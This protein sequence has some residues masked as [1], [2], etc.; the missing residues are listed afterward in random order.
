MSLSIEK[1]DFDQQSQFTGGEI[2]IGT[3]SNHELVKK[4]EPLPTSDL[5]V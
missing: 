1:Q 4:L 3:F 5:T 2:M